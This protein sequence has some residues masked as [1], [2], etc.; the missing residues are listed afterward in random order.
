M[1]TL[2]RKTKTEHL[3]DIIN[4]Y[5]KATNAVRIDMQD[6]AGWAIRN[7]LWMPPRKDSIRQCAH[8]LA[9]AAR[10]EFYDDPQGRHVRKKHA[11][12]LPIVE[13]G[14][15]KQLSLWVDIETASTSDMHLSLQQ[16]RGYIVGDCKQLKTDLDSFNENYN[17]G[18][19]I[20]LSFDFT[21]DVAEAAMGT[22]YPESAPVRPDST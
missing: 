4:Q 9:R 13:A 11:L 19:P 18:A 5:I 6:V 15:H 20:Q 12:R 7:E 16:R 3:Q 17:T 14:E 2:L 8:E 22:K 21:E 1:P 10:D